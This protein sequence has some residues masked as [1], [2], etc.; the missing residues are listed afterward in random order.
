MTPGTVSAD[1]MV[2]VTGNTALVPPEFE[3]DRKNVK[4]PTTVAEGV[5]LI[6]PVLGSSIL[7]S[8]GKP[9][10]LKLVGE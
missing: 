6:T 10:T 5:P 9:V 8:A 2:S 1:A 7:K 4:V 3:A